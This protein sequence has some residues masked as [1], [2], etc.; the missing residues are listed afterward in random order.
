MHKNK[1]ITII[2]RLLSFRH[3]KVISNG[4]HKPITVVFNSFKYLSFE[5]QCNSIYQILIC[6]KLQMF[7]FFSCILLFVFLIAY[8]VQ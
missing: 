8:S 5:L 2:H 7:P 3:E 6:M 4:H 1:I